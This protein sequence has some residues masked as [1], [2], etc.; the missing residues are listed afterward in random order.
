M[1]MPIAG[2]LKND[3]WI[4]DADKPDPK[5]LPK[6]NGI[7]RTQNSN[8]KPCIHHEKIIKSDWKNFF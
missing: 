3:E 6:L 2:A 5:K 8:F 4:E 7:F 1:Q